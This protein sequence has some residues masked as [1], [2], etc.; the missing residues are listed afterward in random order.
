MI[1]V[2]GTTGDSS[3][4]ANCAIPPPKSSSKKQSDLSTK[5]TASP[6]AGLFFLFRPA[7]AG[8]NK[9]SE[10]PLNGAKEDTFLCKPLCQ[11]LRASDS[12]VICKPCGKNRIIRNLGFCSY[13][14]FLLGNWAVRSLMSFFSNP[15]QNTISH[16]LHCWKL[17]HR[18]NHVLRMT[19]K[20]TG[21]SIMIP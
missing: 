4:A 1:R 18:Q 11:D 9:S 3:A 8:R 15:S 16:Y 5:K 7:A 6:R 20:T 14:L 17:H 21:N 19:P 10:A 13:F 12:A 2:P